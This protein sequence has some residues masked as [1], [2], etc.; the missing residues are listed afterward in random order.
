MKKLFLLILML[1]TV[2]FVW[3]VKAQEPVVETDTIQ[4]YINQN[5]AYVPASHTELPDFDLDLKSVID[6]L[7]TYDVQ[8][9]T[10]LLTYMQYYGLTDPYKKRIYINDGSDIYDRR[11]TV[12]HELLH[13][14]Y[15]ERGVQTNY[16]EGELKVEAMSQK[17]YQKLYGVPGPVG[18]PV[19]T[20]KRT[21]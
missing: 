15:R 6:T 16:P 3:P 9:E 2:S 7:T 10:N 18:V 5:G 20:P 17:M 14:M 8:H 12:I 21:R 1:V 19:A 4:L 13:V 11:D